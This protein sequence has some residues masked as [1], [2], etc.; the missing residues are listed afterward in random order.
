MHDLDVEGRA[1]DFAGDDTI[2]EVG[3]AVFQ[4]GAQRSDQTVYVA[5]PDAGSGASE[6]VIH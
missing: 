4:A 5:C 2:V 6:A 3:L 1:F